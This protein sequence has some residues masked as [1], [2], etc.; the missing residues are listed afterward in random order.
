MS[1]GPNVSPQR[2]PCLFR[3]LTFVLS[4]ICLLIPGFLIFNTLVTPVKQVKTSYC[5]LRPLCL[6][7]QEVR[8]TR[9]AFRLPL[10]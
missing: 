5:M 10:R 7:S 9:L 4:V 3:I 6:V 2:L 1:D 8:V